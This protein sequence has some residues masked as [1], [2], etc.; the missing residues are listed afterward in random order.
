MFRFAS[1]FLPFCCLSDSLLK[2]SPKL[3]VD[4][5]NIADKLTTTRKIT[6]FLGEKLLGFR[7]KTGDRRVKTGVWSRLF[8]LTV[9]HAR[10]NSNKYWTYPLFREKSM[11][12]PGTQG[13]DNKRAKNADCFY[14]MK[15]NAT[16][17]TKAVGNSHRAQRSIRVAGSWSPWVA[18]ADVRI[19]ST[20]AKN[21]RIT[22][23]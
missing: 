18:I 17:L 12:G 15:A 1:H 13:T 8:R 3:P 11:A 20:K 5:Y 10:E 9:G 2:F 7:P 22:E 23:P 16:K 14:A 21:T 4:T 6:R 19:V